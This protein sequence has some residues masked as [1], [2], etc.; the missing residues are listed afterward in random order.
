MYLESMRVVLRFD[1]GYTIYRPTAAYTPPVLLILFAHLAH[2]QVQSEKKR[3]YS[4]TPR[5]DS[6]HTKVRQV[7]NIPGITINQLIKGNI[8][9]AEIHCTLGISVT[10]QKSGGQHP[11]QYLSSPEEHTSLVHRFASPNWHSDTGAE[12]FLF[13]LSFSGCASRWAWEFE[14]FWTLETRAT[15]CAWDR[16]TQVE[17]KDPPRIGSV[18][19]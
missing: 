10:V 1:Q 14:I 19:P 18:R 12:N 6:G 9:L 15:V 16:C 3:G 2:V 13:S 4:Q 17:V 5:V 11:C 8:N 7:S